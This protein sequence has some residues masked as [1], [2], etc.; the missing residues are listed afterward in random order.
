M[1]RK[2]LRIL[3]TLTI[4]P[5]FVI[6]GRLLDLQI[7][8]PEKNSEVDVFEKSTLKALPAQR[9][10]IY[11]RNG[12][13]LA[14]NKTE[15]DLFFTL[16]S[17]FKREL[18]L[19][20]F[21]RVLSD[22]LCT[23]VPRPGPLD[24]CSCSTLENQFQPIISNSHSL[25][26]Y[27][28]NILDLPFEQ[29]RKEWLSNIETKNWRRLK[30]GLRKSLKDQGH[31]FIPSENKEIGSVFIDP[32]AFLAPELS[33]LE[34]ADMNCG[35]YEEMLE[36]VH[37]ASTKLKELLQGDSPPNRY[38]RSR[39]REIERL[40][41]RD[42]TPEAVTR[43]LYHPDRFPGL[44][45]ESRSRR[46]YPHGEYTGLITGYLGNY[47]AGV[48]EEE[49]KILKNEGRLLDFPTK[50]KKAYFDGFTQ[51][52]QK[53]YFGKDLLGRRGLEQAY[54][55]EL[56]GIP[57]LRADY[58]DAL[59][60]WIP[61]VDQ[62]IQPIDG[63]SIQ[64][65][66]DLQLQRKLHEELKQQVRHMG[67]GK[68]GSAIIMDLGNGPDKK[69]PGGLLACVGYPSFNSESFSHDQEYLLQAIRG[70]NPEVSLFNRPTDAYLN[71]GSM[72]KLIV[73]MAAMESGVRI[74]GGTKPGQAWPQLPLQAH[75][76]YECRYVFDNERWE[77]KFKCNSQHQHNHS[78]P[79]LNLVEAIRYSCNTYFYELGRSRLGPSH[80]WDWGRKLGYGRPVYLDLD[81]PRKLQIERRPL[82]AETS[83][84]GKLDRHL[85]RRFPKIL[86]YTIG[87]VYVEASPLQAL[88]S[89]AAIAL[90]GKVPFPYLVEPLPPETINT[91]FNPFPPLRKGMEAAA[92][93]PRGTA[94]K[95][96]IS[97]YWVA[98][99]TG[100]AQTARR[101]AAN[102][103]LYHSWGGG[104]APL[105]KPRIAFI[106]R[107]ELTPNG[108]GDA[109][110]PIIE[111]ILQ[112][113]AEK[114]PELYLRPGEKVGLLIPDPTTNSIQLKEARL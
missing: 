33:L 109:T 50:N 41:V 94:N 9:G 79:D 35:I 21:Q 74:G 42:I 77:G 106:V 85:G 112:Y 82:R 71:P 16:E 64:T 49:L 39:F 56:R 7:L 100:T 2:R 34:L 40:L 73:A 102:N 30:Y 63:K 25:R 31:E 60:R 3:I 87:Q 26:S 105:D 114:D 65:T 45:V 24:M 88:R 90:N 44:T 14:G 67:N 93:L 61:L 48:N 99:K 81:T 28:R 108:G 55:D 69:T 46:I 89:L 43:V 51:Q 101:D 86:H 6:I 37:G 76:R 8:F 38:E 110:A 96:T 32:R 23:E 10:E 47:L 29:R 97:D 80:L 17:F 113:F 19:A 52:R 27:K 78:R 75:E 22:E 53:A 84:K 91:R 5:Y 13:L 58:Q 103:K 36:R 54:E 107:F 4:I 59:Q 57:G 68:G 70:E 92:R 18:Y 62:P 20:E 15:F 83:R 1:V 66:L 11:D 104:F 98:L 12:V 72:F 95:L 111:K